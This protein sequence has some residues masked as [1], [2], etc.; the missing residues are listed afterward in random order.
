[1]RDVLAKIQ[2]FAL[3]ET[4][5][6]RNQGNYLFNEQFHDN[7]MFEQYFKK[8]KQVFLS[9]HFNKSQIFSRLKRL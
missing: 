1:M 3:K 5:N 2:W 6:T 8:N 7:F 4:N 9:D